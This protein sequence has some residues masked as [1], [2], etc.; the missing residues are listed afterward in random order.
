MKKYSKAMLVLM[1]TGMTIS[2]VMPVNAEQE[3]SE[4]EEVVY[5][6]TTADGEVTEVNVV[7]MFEGGNIVDYGTYSEVKNMTGTSQ[8][9]QDGDKITFSEDEDKVYYQGTLE[10][11]EIPW[12]V[13]LTYYLD[14]EEISPE[15]LAEES[16]S[17]TIHFVISKNESCEKEFYDTY[18]LQASFTF[19]TALC[20]N[21]N[22]PDATIANVGSDKQLT[23]TVLPGK[24]LDTE[25]TME[26]TDFEMEAVS[27]N[28][29]LLNLNVEIDDEEL[30]DQVE[31][32]MSAISEI[33][34]GAALL[35][36][37]SE[38]LVSGTGTLEDGMLSLESGADELDAGVQSLKTGMETVQNGIDAL[39]AQSENLTTGSQQILS[40]LENVESSLQD[41][42]LTTD[43]LVTLT[44]AS[45]AIKNGIAD[46]AQG[47]ASL[48]SSLGYAQYKA[49]MYANGLDID[50]LKASN[51]QTISALSQQIQSLQESL[52]EVSGVEGYEAQAQQIQ[53]EINTLQN[54][55]TLL[56]GNNA[57]VSGTESYLNSMEE[58]C[59]QLSEGI[60]SLEE[61]YTEF[62]ANVQALVNTLSQ[63]AVNMSDLSSGISTLVNEYEKL[64][65]GVSEYTAGVAQLADG[66]GQLLSGV[67]SLASGSQT[68]LSGSENL[69]S[70]VQELYDG[71]SEY[72]DGVSSLYEGTDELQSQTDDLDTRT[73]DQ[74]DEILSSITS[75]GTDIQSF[76]SDKNV[77]TDSVQF[78]IQTEKIEADDSMEEAET[79]SEE[80]GFWEK[81]LELFGK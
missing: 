57:A 26:V 67:S 33:N 42:S 74:I 73:E 34:D 63:L 69:S 68:L 77:N 25:I 1:M 4:K 16:G 20:E 9:T 18:A 17:L 75:E 46:L 78:V 48:Q 55:I 56:K 62:D 44:N 39:N 41:I 65:E 81:L 27:I 5:V 53:T 7:N 12:D 22:A 10:N 24:G 58:A 19:D 52:N 37:N 3:A 28:G 61:Q 47:A 50:S 49:A 2:A 54:V 21:I 51:E 38:D 60:S 30:M 43:E 70:G 29:I 45:S 79:D 71:I 72:C 6:S 59:M 8:I 31:T 66:Y 11:A 40:A 35:D 14:G 23:Y 80:A 36:E 13:S 76:V 15:D 32:L 64:D